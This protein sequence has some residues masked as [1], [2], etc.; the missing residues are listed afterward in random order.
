MDKVTLINKEQKRLI[1]LNEVLAG[2][3]TGPMAAE[4]LYLATERITR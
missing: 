4:L 2:R 3:L 1:L